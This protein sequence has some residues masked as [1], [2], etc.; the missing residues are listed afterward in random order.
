[1]ANTTSLRIGVLCDLKMI[2]GHPFHAIGDKYLR[3]ITDHLQAQVIM[4]P[5]LPQSLDLLDEVD[6]LMLTGSHSNIEPHHYGEPDNYVDDLRDKARDE[7]SPQLIR[8]ALENDI[9]I[10][11]ICRGFQ[12][13]NVT[14]GGSMHQRLADVADMIEHREDKEAELE[15]QY[16]KSHEVDLLAGGKLAAAYQSASISVNSLHM[17]GVKQLAEEMVTEALAP[18]GLVE[19]FSLRSDDRFVLA[20]QW[21]PEWKV[22]EYPDYQVIFNIFAEACEQRKS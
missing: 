17:Q 4:L 1:M 18:D 13:L 19:A 5:A 8:K 15:Q 12:E 6:G 3:A 21:H 10:L 16:D 14:F 22:M 2:A 7:F 9:P 20:V 11:G